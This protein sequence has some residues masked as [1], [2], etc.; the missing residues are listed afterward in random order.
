MSEYALW[1]AELQ[2]LHMRPWDREAVRLPP[3]ALA[4]SALICSKAPAEERHPP[5]AKGEHLLPALSDGLSAPQP[6]SSSAGHEADISH[7]SG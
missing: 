7:F 2:A 5:V 4:Y 3:R 1:K 6:F